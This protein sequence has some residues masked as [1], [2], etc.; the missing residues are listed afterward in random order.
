MIWA[1]HVA[2]MGEVRNAYDILV[3]KPEKRSPLGRQSHIWKVKIT[4]NLTEIEWRVW[5]GR[6]WHRIGTSGAPL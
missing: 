4:M 6:I 2:C 3:G 5:T 1:G